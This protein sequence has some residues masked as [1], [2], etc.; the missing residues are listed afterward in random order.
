[1]NF[2]A[3]KNTIGEICPEGYEP[4]SSFRPDEEV[5]TLIASNSIL[6]RMTPSI[7]LSALGNKC[8]I[9][10]KRK[11]ETMNYDRQKMESLIYRFFNAIDPSKTNTKKYK[12]LFE[13]MTDAQ[14]KKYFKDMFNNKYAY[15]ILEIVDFEHTVSMENVEAAAKVLDIPLYEY[16]TLPHLTM[17]KEHAVTTKVPVPVGYINEKRTQQTLK[18]N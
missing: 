5:S 12:A 9:E 1:M 4:Y 8:I 3:L 14:F 11:L 18:T 6:N 17:D 13:P 2:T 16:V 15:L 7:L 10:L